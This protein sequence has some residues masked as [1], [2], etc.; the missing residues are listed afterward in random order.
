M[1]LLHL[2]LSPSNHINSSICVTTNSK[3]QI[4]VSASNSRL[5]FTSIIQGSQSTSS[6]PVFALIRAICPVRLPGSAFD[7]VAIS[8]DSGKFAI[9]QLDDKNNTISPLNVGL[10]SFGRSGARKAVPGQYIAA[11]P[12]GRAVMLSSIE[13]PKICY[14]LNR[15]ADLKLVI[16]SPLSVSGGITFCLVSVDVGYENP[17]F[18]TIEL[19]ETE[20]V[21]LYNLASRIL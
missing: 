3:S 21:F 7:Y 16:N 2:T 10:E 4:I 17:V 12:K 15:D 14:I 13:G 9:I 19:V 11:D 20:K 8:S 5:K 6:F 18:A 1:H